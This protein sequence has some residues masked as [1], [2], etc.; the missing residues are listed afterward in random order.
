MKDRIYQNIAKLAL[1][2]QWEAKF[3][4]TSYGFRPKRN[5]HDAIQ[6]IHTTVG[7]KKVWIFE[8]DFKGCFDNLNHDYI[9]EQIKGFPAFNVIAKWLK[10]GFVDNNV[11]HESEDG[12]P[13]G[14]IISPLLANIALHGLENLFNIKYRKVKRKTKT[15]YE[16]LAKFAV[17]KYADDFVIMCESEEDAYGLYNK[18]KPY[19]ETRGLS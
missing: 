4:P 18:L 6:R 7:N 8:G 10:A 2:P 12:T 9:L 11:F 3:E 15:S 17:T 1:E 19:L 5:C 16:N 14:G 13:Q